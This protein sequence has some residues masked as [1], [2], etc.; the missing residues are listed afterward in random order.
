ML[1]HINVTQNYGRLTVKQTKPH[2][3]AIQG[4][5]SFWRR[6]HEAHQYND[7]AFT[8]DHSYQ[9]PKTIHQHLFTS[10][11]IQIHVSATIYVLCR[12]NASII[13]KLQSRIMVA[14][15]SFSRAIKSTSTSYKRVKPVMKMLL[16]SP[17]KSLHYT[18]IIGT[19]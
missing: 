11:G 4:Q 2:L 7:Q 18:V 3:P 6:T 8:S 9:S 15:V 14:V 10:F 17:K 5:F 1:L 16:S 19:K 12:C 13:E